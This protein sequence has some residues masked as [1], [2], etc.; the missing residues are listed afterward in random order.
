MTDQLRQKIEQGLQALTPNYNSEQI[1]KLEKFVLLLQKWN[2][3]YNLI[4]DSATEVI[5]TRHIFDSLSISPYITANC[6]LD[7]GTGAGFPGIPLAIV[8]P[9]TDFVL[10]DSNGK[11]TRFLFQVKL[12]LELDNVSVENCRIEHYQSNRQID[13]VTCRAFSSLPDMVE[14]TASILAEGSRLLAMKGR[15]PELE[16]EALTSDYKITNIEKLAIPGDNAERHLIQV[17]WAV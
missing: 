16:L 11:K 10:L 2:A 17:E 1:E 13:I 5:L 6:V 7:V 3:S 15:C 12:A 14:K 8:H 4:A 9:D